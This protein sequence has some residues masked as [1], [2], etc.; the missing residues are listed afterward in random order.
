MNFSHRRKLHAL[1]ICCGIV[2]FL[3]GGQ[4]AEA[5]AQVPAPLRVDP[6]LLGLPPIKPAEAPAPAAPIVVE[7][8][9]APAE[10]ARSEAKPVEARAVEGNKV[11]ARPLADEPE[12]NPPAKASATAARESA[13]RTEPPQSAPPVPK[14]PPS[15]TASQPAANLPVQP[16]PP[17]DQR[18]D[19]V[20]D[21][22][23]LPEQRSTKQPES[24][25]QTPA[26]PVK[27]LARQQ[28]Q[29]SSASPA[30]PLAPLR[31]DPALLGLPPAT[32]AAAA[33]QSPGVVQ[34]ERA[35]ESAAATEAQSSPR[36][37]AS[38]P[39][40]GARSADANKPWYARIWSPIS[41]AYNNG[42]LEFY[43]PFETYHLRSKYTAEKIATYQEHPV[44]FGLGS[45]LYNEKGNW[46][47]VYAMAFQDSHFKPSY[48]AGYGWK[49]I[50]RPAEDVRLGLGYTA[51]LMSRADILSYVPFPIVLPLASVAYRN[52]SLEGTFVPG[53]KG[54]GNIFFIWA[55]WELGKS[56]EAIG[57]P[58]RPAQQPTELATTSFGPSTPVAQRRVPYG[59]VLE[60]GTT[61]RLASPAEVEPPRVAP[62]GR[63]DEELVPDPLPPLALRSSKRMS[64]LPK[65]SKV[66]RPVFLSA[67]RMGG[68]VDREFNAEGEAELRKIG[69]V[70]NAER[71]TYWPIDDEMEAEGNVRLEQNED[72]MTGPKMRMKLEDQ[73]GYFDEPS[74]TLKRQPTPGSKAAAEKEYAARFAEQ[75]SS[76]LTSGFAPPRV[77]D[78]KPGQ[79]KL[80]D[81][82]K[83]VRTM[84][85]A[86]GD[87]DR[88]DFEGENH[89]RMTNATYTT[90]APGDDDWYVKAET[91]K[92]DYDK[93]VAEGSDGTVYFLGTP[94]LYS[95]WLSFSLNNQR[96]SGFLAPSFGTNS[97]NGIELATPYYWNI[98]PNMDATVTPRVMSKRGLLLSNEF[99]YLDR[100]YGGSYRGQVRAEVLPHD[101]LR[102]GDNRYGFS[103]QHSQ[104]T[105]NGFSGAIN[106]GKVSDDNYFTDLSSHISG[107]A[108]TQLLQQ[109]ILSYGGGGWWSATANFQRYQTLQPD[110]KNPVLEPYRLLPQITVSARKP[111]LYMTDSSF[112]GQYTNFTVKERIQ[113][114]NGVPTLYPDGQRT[115]L[116][117][118][119]ALPYVT[120]G[121][122]V[123]PKVGVNVRNYQLTGQAAG[124]PDSIST[125]LPVFSLDS[126]MTFERPSNWYG[127][128]Y[129]QTLEPRLYYVNIPY[130]NQERIPIFD[131]A[132]ADFNFAQIFSE[133]QFSGWDRINNANQ[134]TAAATSRLLEPSSGSEIMRAMLGQRF[135]FTRNK[136]ALTASA[137]PD[138]DDRKWDK[139]DFLAAFSGQILPKVYT[140]A[141]WQYNLGDRQ[142]K[143]YSIGTRYQPEPGKVFNA[144]YR[145]NRDSTAPID[146]ID[147]SGQW[148]LSGR[149]HAVGRINYSFKDD[150][151]NVSTNTQGGRLIESIAGLEYNGGCW[152]LR[153]VVQRIAL[154]QDR[155]STS[156][157]IQLELNDFSRIG[158]NPLNLLKRNVQG[159]G[160]IN[161]PVAD[162]VFGE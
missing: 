1:L 74:Y 52:F 110:P 100:A 106:Y 66:S 18:K 55:K 64:P 59:P 105:A 6:V 13:P 128:D 42:A 141:A 135:Y 118:Q 4:I 67:Y 78:I 156:F 48:I 143:R 53:G 124:T 57:T 24:G 23:S 159:Y 126:G 16:T 125:T 3:F 104:A 43:L 79:T 30:S 11:E 29:A 88:I 81:S 87:A 119:V 154:T 95:P 40:M 150:A 47:G 144:S 161:Q 116:Y 60:P 147:L 45:G 14:S 77:L 129:T 92:L 76:W 131:S 70:V 63:R 20:K 115:V 151:T 8:P 137:I 39:R 123:T 38:A 83:G 89:V 62:T 19:V 117:P 15:T 160:L 80:K 35:V 109:G 132:L 140:D 97:D 157:F 111:D 73:V 37:R 158:S 10:K 112:L 34:A 103:V 127:R 71:L 90:C 138:T 96:K 65:D 58:A 21:G 2:C 54:N 139:S 155:A 122:Y 28:T 9:P 101:N 7:T 114:V 72:V 85:E 61:Q 136:V 82:T 51:G 107:S 46:E 152:V 102:S 113:N 98:A 84:V 25:P 133:N 93:E 50:W 32:A 99:R 56:G 5:Q 121:W 130:K 44:G 75:N 148:P 41:N 120:P 162:P 68:D 91:L 149:W 27:P 49:A 22:A 69:T 17:P 12:P 146:Q 153:G 145:Y 31:V 134:L 108:N 142:V 36:A 86:R 26:Q 33:P 94:I